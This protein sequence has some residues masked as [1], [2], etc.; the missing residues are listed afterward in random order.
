MYDKARFKIIL[1]EIF[2]KDLENECNAYRRA[3]EVNY[4]KKYDGLN[5]V[6]YPRQMFMNF[7]EKY[8]CKVEFTDVKNEHYWNSKYMYNCYI[9][10]D[11]CSIV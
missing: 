4:D 3:S 2:D 1:L 7:A 9:Y 6:F 11:N 8:G 10:K 5:K